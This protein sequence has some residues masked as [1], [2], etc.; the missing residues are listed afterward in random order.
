M[1]KEVKKKILKK[2]ALSSLLV[3]IIGSKYVANT[4]WANCKDS[5]WN[6]NVG[7]NTD[8]VRYTFSR[9][10]ENTSKAYCYIKNFSNKESS[11]GLIVDLVDGNSGKKF[12]KSWPRTLY[13]AGKYS[14]TNYAYEDRGS[15]C[16][17]KL[18]FSS[19]N[20]RWTYTWSAAGL[21]SP[22]SSK[23]YS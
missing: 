4:C 14:I 12:S 11:D 20:F 16:S 2:I 3:L 6:Y 22:D 17:V 10:K 1:K 23:N 8:D 9:T 19:T 21:W 7:G 5:S 13:S 18:K 15:A